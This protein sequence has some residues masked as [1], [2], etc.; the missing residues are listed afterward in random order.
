MDS[1]PRFGSGF[2]SKV[3]VHE[4][5]TVFPITLLSSSAETVSYFAL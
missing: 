1:N 5:G 4:R 2:L 3:V